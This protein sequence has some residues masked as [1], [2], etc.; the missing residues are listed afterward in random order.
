MIYVAIVTDGIGNVISAEKVD[1]SDVLISHKA[2]VE[3]HKGKHWTV[4]LFEVTEGINV[5]SSRT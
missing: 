2:L 5:G 1:V 3:K 4:S